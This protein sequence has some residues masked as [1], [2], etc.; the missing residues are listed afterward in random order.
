MTARYFDAQTDADADTYA[1]ADA[2]ADTD[3]RTDMS[4]LMNALF[5]RAY[6]LRQIEN[7][8]EQATLAFEEEIK[9]VV[10]DIRII[11]NAADSVVPDIDGINSIDIGNIDNIDSVVPDIAGT[12]FAW[13]EAE[14]AYE[15]VI[16]DIEE[17]LSI[18]RSTYRERHA[19]ASAALSQA[20]TAFMAA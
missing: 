1:D 12:D 20:Q 13:Q 17:R 2:D 6:E 10:D 16:R 4:F 11:A 8:V 14:S 7:E 18:A 5:S 9:H 3:T 15:D 19:I